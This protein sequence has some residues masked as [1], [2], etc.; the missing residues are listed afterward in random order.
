MP[1]AKFLTP[2][3]FDALMSK[4]R[5]KGKAFGDKAMSVVHRL[6]LD[7]LEVK[8]DEDE[9][10]PAA[11]AWG[12]E[13]EWLAVR[14]YEQR[15]LVSVHRSHFKISPTLTYV[16]GT[17]DGLVGKAGGIETK[18]PF[19]PINHLKFEEQFR[20]YFYQVYGYV[21]VY[22]I[23]WMDFISFDPRYPEHLNLRVKRVERDEKI[24]NALERRCIDAQNLALGLVAKME[25]EIC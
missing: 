3:T 24:I 22:E 11:C 4:G 12:N 19:N 5:D 7:L 25:K 10:T 9:F 1:R 21:W 13:Y 8:P 14:T 16:G 20:G 6:A 18:C 23:E 2:S 17:A 15:R